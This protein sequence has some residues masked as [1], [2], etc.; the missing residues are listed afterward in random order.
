ML[1]D[2]RPTGR[3]IGLYSGF[4]FFESVIDQF[5]KR[6]DY[7]GVAPR[8]FNGR[9]DADALGKGEFILRPGLVYRHTRQKRKWW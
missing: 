5:G 7:V 1:H 4:E 9:P 8:K 3:K 6:F 2:V